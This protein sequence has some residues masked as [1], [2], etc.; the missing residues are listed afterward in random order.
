MSSLQNIH[1]NYNALGSITEESFRYYLEFVFVKSMKRKGV[2]FPV[3]LFIDNHTSHVSMEFSRL[4]NSLGVIL[5]ALYPNT[6][7]LHSAV[8]KD[9]KAHWSSLLL[10]KRGE[11][12]QFKVNMINFPDL[13]LELL[14][15][16]HNTQAVKHGFHVCGIFPWNINDV[17]WS[18]LLASKIQDSGRSK[19]VVVFSGMNSQQE[20]EKLEEDKE[21][22]GQEEN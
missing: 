2:Q 11:N 7:L 21:N 19:E 20:N 13:L 15:T 4:A 10:R 9:L 6:T 16:L 12:N 17:D 3:I 5:I 8:F 14:S 22:K 18:K 1:C